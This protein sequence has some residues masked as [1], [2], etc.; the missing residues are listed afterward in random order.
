MKSKKWLLPL[1][2]IVALLAIGTAGAAGSESYTDPSG[3][4]GLAPDVVGLD[5][6]N[7]DKGL[8]T[9]ALKLGN[10]T[11]LTGDD[12]I[13][14]FLTTREE[15][16]VI[17]ADWADRS[18]ALGRWNGSDY[19]YDVP[20]DT[21][22][23]RDGITFWINRSDLANAETLLIQTASFA[24]WDGEHYQH[25]DSAPDA[26]PGGSV[27]WPYVLSLAPELRSVK[28]TFTP[29]KPRAGKRFAVSGARVALGTGET[30]QAESVTCSARLAGR[31]L[32]LAGRCAWNL[33]P[34]ANGKRLTVTVK[35]TYHGA[36]RSAGPFAF[37]VGR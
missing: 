2:A 21:L 30:V 16:Y 33:P 4:S 23:T 27:V 11:S 5:V 31:V 15:D 14:I 3:D 19:D 7:D 9:F 34:S 13:A 18:Y 28:P 8:L 17:F 24:G 6:S 10:R 35:V 36:T 37:T 25:R 12:A 1:V 32:R 22:L 29:L 20:Q 26:I